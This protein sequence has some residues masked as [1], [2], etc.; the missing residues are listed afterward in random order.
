LFNIIVDIKFN[1]HGRFWNNLHQVRFKSKDWKAKSIKVWEPKPDSTSIKS[2][3]VK[4]VL[5]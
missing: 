2:G 4:L 1:A 3:G 5:E